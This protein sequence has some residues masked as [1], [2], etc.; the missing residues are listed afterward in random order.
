MKIDQT[1]RPWI[2]AVGAVLVISAII[3]TVYAYQTPGGARGGTFWGLTFGI[4]GYALMLFEGFLSLRKKKPIWRIGKTTTWMR[5]H[6]WL[7]L[8]SLPL[9]LFH[10]GFAWRGQLTLIMMVLFF[11]VVL[12]GIAGA[13][14][15]HYLPRTIA[16]QIPL[17]TIYEEIPH[18]RN[19]LKEEADEL[20]K[21]LVPNVEIEFD[22][23]R[24]LREAYRTAIRPYLDAPE[25]AGVELAD[26]HRAA[27]LFESMRV[28]L[29]A[30]LHPAIGDLENICEEERQL[31][32]QGRFY[33]WLHA[34]LIVHVPLSIALLLLGGIHAIMAL[35][36]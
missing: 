14:L 28:A 10:A 2:A 17:E 36:Y 9:I 15:Q 12:S 25:K 33:R 6:L 23:R 27:V 31:T 29:P 20:M 8:L 3:Y 34:W 11:I 22:D 7:G 32:R 21:D 4:V 16:K 35:R 18:I 24:R 19:V 5:G 26:E 13:V 1:H 30:E